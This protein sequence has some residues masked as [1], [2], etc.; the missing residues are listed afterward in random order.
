MCHDEAWDLAMENIL[1]G[2]D[3]MWEPK[4]TTTITT[5]RT[6]TVKQN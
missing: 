2:N 5:T 1:S 6:T 3:P 4:T